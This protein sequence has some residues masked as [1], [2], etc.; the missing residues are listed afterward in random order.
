MSNKKNLVIAS[1]LRKRLGGLWL[2]FAASGLLYLRETGYKG[3]GSEILLV[4]GI[5]LMVLAL[6]WMLSLTVTVFVPGKVPTARKIVRHFGLFKT[7]TVVDFDQV[8]ILRRDNIL[9]YCQLYAYSSLD[10]LK[11]KLRTDEM[12][13]YEKNQKPLPGLVVVDHT[14]KK[15]C[16]K[17]IENIWK[18]YDLWEDT[19]KEE[20]KSESDE[21]DSED[22][23]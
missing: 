6:H 22:D 13:P 4:G 11:T 16:E 5:I 18:L 12:E 3:S 9:P 23:V 8:D 2:A 14:T 15:E 21:I 20:V 7:E 10:Y 19:P 1:P 17:H